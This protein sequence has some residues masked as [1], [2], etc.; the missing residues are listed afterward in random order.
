MIFSFAGSLWSTSEN[1]GI[2]N[3]GGKLSGVTG[4]LFQLLWLGLFFFLYKTTPKQPEKIF[5]N[6]EIDKML[7]EL[8]STGGVKNEKD[9][10]KNKY[11]KRSR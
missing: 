11:K 2:L 9:N 10:S 4:V 5:H 3:N 7:K 6:P 8:N 1:W